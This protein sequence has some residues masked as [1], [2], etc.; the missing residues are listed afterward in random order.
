MRQITRLY[1]VTGICA[2]INA[3]E[4]KHQKTALPENKQRGML[5]LKKKKSSPHV[6]IT[7]HLR[8]LAK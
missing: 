7:I 3:R 5:H 1:G 2:M 8:R 4:S 6:I